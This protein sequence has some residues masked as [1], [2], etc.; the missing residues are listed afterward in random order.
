MTTRRD[1]ENCARSPTTMP[2]TIRLLPPS[3]TPTWLR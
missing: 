1:E 2:Q 3:Y